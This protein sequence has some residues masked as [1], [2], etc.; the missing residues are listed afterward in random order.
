MFDHNRPD[1]KLTPTSSER[2]RYNYSLF[3]QTAKPVVSIVT[4][5]YNTGSIFEETAHVVFAQSFQQWEWIIVD[6]GSTDQR[7]IDLLEKIKKDPRVKVIRRKNRGLSAARNVGFHSA[8]TN[9]I[10]QLDSDDLIEPTAVEKSLWYAVRHSQAAFINGFSGAFGAQEYIWCNGFHERSY[11]LIDN[12]VCPIALVRRDVHALVGGYDET[13]KSGLEDWDFWLRCA[14]HGFWGVTLPEITC[15]YRRRPDHS[16]RWSEYN[17]QGKQRF[18]QNSKKKYPKIYRKG[19][20]ALELDTRTERESPNL[21]GTNKLIKRDRRVL[22]FL[23]WLEMGGADQFNINLI[24]E[25]KKR[26]WEISIVCTLPSNHPWLAEF[27]K[28]TPD[29][30]ILNHFLEIEDVPAFVE[31]LIVSRNFDLVLI[32]QSLM[33]YFLL[34]FLRA[35]FPQLALCDYNHMVELH[36]LGGGYPNMS[37]ENKSYLDLQI[38]A[39]EHVANW[40]I[41]K[42]AEARNVVVCYINV[43]TQ[44]FKPNSVARRNWRTRLSIPDDMPVIVYIA[45]FTEQKRPLLM[46][47]I[48]RKLRAETKLFR[49]LCVGNG[50]L[51]GKMDKFVTDHSLQENV[52]FLGAQKNQDVAEILA[53]SDM[54]LLPSAYEGVALIAFEAMATGLPVLASD[55]GGQAELVTERTGCLIRLNKE[56]LEADQFLSVLRSWLSDPSEMKSKGAAGREIILKKFDLAVLG[57]KMNEAFSRAMQNAKARSDTIDQMSIDRLK[58]LAIRKSKKAFEYNWHLDWPVKETIIQRSKRVS[59]SYIQ[60]LWLIGTTYIRLFIF[61]HPSSNE[62][63]KRS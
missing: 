54:L 42:G 19:I 12:R 22:L 33:G 30:F 61:G 14:E 56:S 45:R 51:S 5:F 53:A 21:A 10:F 52:I 25:L 38:A 26:G 23:P 20:A 13:M 50:P 8:T 3:D 62:K 41:G 11:F 47:M 1:F 31:Y 37:V 36:W 63:G 2:P 43:S 40:M 9:F 15:W 4:P 58:A 16:E 57:P 6:D 24:K 44:D 46:L 18:V 39:S 27:A 7:S 32:I 55:V 48:A 28:E 35:R 60:Q 17:E 59:S 34:P 29:I 49:L